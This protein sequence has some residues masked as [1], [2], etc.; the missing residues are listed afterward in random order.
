MA[1]TIEDFYAGESKNFTITLS[2][3]GAAQD[4]TSDTVTFRMKANYDDTDANAAL[5]ETANVASQGASGAAIFT[6][7]HSDTK[8]LTPGD[9]FWDIEWNI[10][11][12]DEYVFPRVGPDTVTIK[13]RVSDAD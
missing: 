1:T 9:Y 2:I 5:S 3:D 4:I 12:G 6:L 13:F 7:E 10:S 8:D 11:G